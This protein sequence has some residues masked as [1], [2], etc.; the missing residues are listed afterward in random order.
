MDEDRALGEDTAL[1]VADDT[2]AAADAGGLSA[3]QA[4]RGSVTR[5]VTASGCASCGCRASC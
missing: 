5:I 1:R 3:R 2:A 4:A